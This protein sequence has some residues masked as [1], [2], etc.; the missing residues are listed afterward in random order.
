M[1]PVYIAVTIETILKQARED[2]P[3]TR[4]L[5]LTNHNLF[6]MTSTGN[7]KKYEHLGIVFLTS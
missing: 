1:S 5:L 2:N 3:V 4:R 6:F 7:H